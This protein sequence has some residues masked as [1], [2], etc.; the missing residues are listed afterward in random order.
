MSKERKEHIKDIWKNKGGGH[1][2][3][4]D[5]MY[6]DYIINEIGNLDN[7]SVLEVG[8]GTGRFALKLLY[9]NKITKYTILDLKKKI[10]DSIKFLKSRK[11]KPEPIFSKDY[12]DL[13]NR[14][15]GLFVAN[16]VIP[17]VPVDYRINLLNNVLPNCENAMIIGILEV[18]D[19]D[20]YKEWLLQ[21][22]N[23]NFKKVVVKK[24]KYLNCYAVIG[25]KKKEL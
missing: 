13:F 21:L 12:E 2:T 24:T 10:N 1:Y 4:Q 7:K 18:D 5:D 22:F 11:F 23:D 6:I 8:A 19:Q 25:I 17:E 20:D 14:N 3:N 9:S 16:V 15:F